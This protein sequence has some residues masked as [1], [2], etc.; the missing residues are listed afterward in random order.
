MIERF[1]VPLSKKAKFGQLKDLFWNE[2]KSVGM[3]V[4][5]NTILLTLL[6]VLL[7]RASILDG[8]APFGIAYVAAVISKERRYN[9]MPLFVMLGILTGQQVGGWTKYGTILLGAWIVFS[10]F[11]EKKPLSFL[12]VATIGGA[13]VF[14]IGCVHA[15]ITGLYIYD[16][17]MIAFE[18]VVTF[19]FIYILS[20]ALPVVLQRTNRKKLSNEELVCIAISMAIAITGFTNVII[21]GYSLKNIFGILLTLIFAYLGGSGVGASVGVTIGIIT[22]MST[23]GTPAVIGIYGF[24]G[25]LAGIFKDLGKFGSAIGMILGNGILTFYINGSTEVIL[26]FGEILTAITLFILMPKSIIQYMDKFS[27]G[28]I[29]I[30]AWDKAYSERIK[31]IHHERMREYAEVFSQL[32]S[33][34][35][36]ISVKEKMIDQQDLACLVDQVANKIC[37][38]CGMCRSCWQMGFYDTYNGIVEVIASLESTGRISSDKVPQSLKRRCIRLDALLQ[39]IRDTFELYRVQ[40]QWERK[41]FENRTLIAEQF[42]GISEI[43][44]ELVQE[45]NEEWIFKTGMEDDLYVAFDQEGISVDSITVLER[46]GGKFEIDIKRRACYDR[47]QCEQRIA[48]LVSKVIGREVIRNNLH[49]NSLRDTNT[50]LFKLVEAERYRGSTG[51]ARISKDGGYICGDNYSYMHLK[52][53]FYMM[54]LSDGMGSGEKA[55]KESLTTINLLE[56]LLEAGFN[57]ELAIKTINSILVSKSSEEIFSTID[58]SLINLYTGRLECIKIGAAPSFIK[59]VNGNVEVI[60]ST[61][62]PVGILNNIDIESFGKKI[63]SGDLVVMMSDGVVDADKDMEDKENWVM[64]A[65]Q[66]IDSKNPQAIA[67]HLLDLAIEKYGERIEDDMTILVTRIWESQKSQ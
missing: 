12:G 66:K 53:S 9:Y 23:I 30:L 67:D 13:L 65:I 10:I 45:I 61:S 60:R 25:L 47:K 56:Q 19:V 17:F 31:E 40:Y 46:S 8:L 18:S 27:N 37:N 15:Y 38:E 2:K 11:R 24:S 59:R 35:N 20:Y 21:A 39:R 43:F 48:P 62:L 54:A 34:Y 57:R 55:A 4:N 41:L 58:L 36:Q 3:Y 16:I 52:D 49:C 6:A 44:D 28:S 5:K 64:E 22:S 42:R 1:Q 26:Q 7:G 33:T 51:V 63:N 29:G 32:A 14:V 50:C